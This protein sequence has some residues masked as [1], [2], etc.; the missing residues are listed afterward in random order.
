M[1]P[2]GV[3]EGG[4]NNEYYNNSNFPEEEGQLFQQNISESRDDREEMDFQQE[5]NFSIKQ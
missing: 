3:S 4:D 5:Y 2:G 1:N